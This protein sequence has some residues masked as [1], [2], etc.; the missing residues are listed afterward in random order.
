MQG[1]SEPSVE[2]ICSTEQIPGQP[3]LSMQRNCLK[4]K[5]TGRQRQRETEMKKQ[6]EIGTE[7]DITSP[8]RLPGPP[9]LAVCVIPLDKDSLTLQATGISLDDHL[10][11]ETDFMTNQ[12]TLRTKCMNQLP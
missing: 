9:G 2:T 4:E 12:V 3:G 8:P 10:P 5:E 1:Q 7:R 11:E 6:K